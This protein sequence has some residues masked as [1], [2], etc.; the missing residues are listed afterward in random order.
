MS[1]PVFDVND[2]FDEDYLYFY[3]SRLEEV[4]DADTSAI[5]R[6]LELE[7]GIDLLDLACGHGRIANRL[8]ERGARVTGLDTK[9]L[10]LDRA[11]AQAAAAGL[12]VDYVEGDMRSLPWPDGSFDR[13]IS[14]FTSFGYFAD[15]ENRRVLRE[16]CRVLRPGGKL[17]IENNNLA[18]LLPRWL[19]VV[20]VE[21]DGDLAIDRARFD[22]TAGRSTTERVIV[23]DGRTRRFTFSVRMFI[24]I[25]LRDWL[26]DAGFATVDF[27]GREGEPLTARSGRMITI[28]RR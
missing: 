28:A 20:V 15:D 6:L 13:V 9:A 5:W 27:Y 12:E 2:V 18:E 8:A 17:L 10:F 25:E 1:G 24:A 14:W 26:L 3:E 22:P 19:P 4:G 7:R 11:R 16:A 23:R 21:R